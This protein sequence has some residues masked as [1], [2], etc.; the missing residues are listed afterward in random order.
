MIYTNPV[1]KGFCPDPSVCRAEDAYYLAASSFEYFPAIPIFRSTDLINWEQIG[2]CITSTEHLPFEKF[3]NSGGIWAPTIRF[4]GGRFYVTAT[5]DGVGNIIMHTDDITGDWSDPVFAEM[6]GIDPS[7]YFENG[8]TY[9]CTNASSSN[10]EA[11]S[12]A[13]IDPDTGRL[14]SQ[15]CE[16]WNGIGEGWLEAPHIYRIGSWYYIMTAEGGTSYK[17]MITVGRSRELMGKYEPCPHNPILTNRNDTSKEVHC[18]GHGDIIQDTDGNW[19]IYHLA[20][21][22]CINTKTTLGREVFLTPFK[23]NDG[24]PEV[25]GRSARL[26]NEAPGNAV[27]T[28]THDFSCSFDSEKW[29]PQ[30]LFLRNPDRSAYTRGEGKLVMRPSRGGFDIPASPSFAAIRQPDFNC[31]AYVQMD[32]EPSGCGDEAG[33]IIYLQTDFNYRICK[34]KKNG[35]DYIAVYRHA[36]D[37]YEE[38]YSEKIPCGTVVFKIVSDGKHYD[39]F[40]RT[41]NGDMKKVCSLSALLLCTDIPTRCFTGALIGLYAFSGIDNH[42]PAVFRSFHIG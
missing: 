3:G 12:A 2:N 26:I 11:I 29:E 31:S 21:R 27:Q 36:D 38:V 41:V 25:S 35:D 30:W 14:L 7:L 37:M 39:F 16:I 19:W 34:T 17:H 40:C 28:K 15:P 20:S 42:S 33:M 13:E 32:F 9:Y 1:I 8:R 18:S 24:W 10:K 23:W 5:V 6:G 4:S 22:A